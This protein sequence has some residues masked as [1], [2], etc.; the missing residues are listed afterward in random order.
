[1]CFIS[2]IYAG[3]TMCSKTLYLKKKAIP[4]RFS[5]MQVQV[6][7]GVQIG[8]VFP[9]ELSRC[10]CHPAGR[11]GSKRWRP[12]ARRCKFRCPGRPKGQTMQKMV[13]VVNYQWV[14]F[15]P[16]ARTPLPLLHEPAGVHHAGALAVPLRAHPLRAA[17][18]R[19]PL[20]FHARASWPAR[21]QN[22]AMVTAAVEQPW[23]RPQFVRCNAGHSAESAFAATAT[24]ATTRSHATRGS[25]E[26]P[27]CG[28]CPG[29][30]LQQQSHGRGKRRD[31]GQCR[32][33]PR[34]HGGQ[35]PGSGR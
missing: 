18:G 13:V 25:S 35:G 15:L 23:T 2:T 17:H 30:G 10:S 8:R 24:A 34:T 26:A 32:P 20:P 28:D 7:P 11:S 29:D 6:P 14:N 4:E 9:S 31:R 3:N 27:P 33:G 22:A 12:K 21:S 1:M 19:P 16:R 5:P